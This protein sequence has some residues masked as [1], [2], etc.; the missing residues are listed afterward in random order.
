MNILD[1][2][3]RLDLESEKIEDKRRIVLFDLS[4][5]GHHPAYIQ[6]LIQYWCAQRYEGCLDIV[7]VP[8]FIQEHADVVALSHERPD[9]NFIAIT[10]KEAA[11]LWLRKS[12][13]KRTV[14][15]FQEWKLFCKYAV[16]L[17]ATHCL[18]M[19]FDTCQLP[20][21]LGLKSPCPFSG[22][23]FKPTFHYVD[24]SNHA[25]SW[26][27]SVKRR[28]ERSLLSR[29]LQHP[30]FQT[31]FCLDPFAVKYFEALQGN[32]HSVFLP[33]PVQITDDSEIQLDTLRNELNISSDKLIFLV[34]G[35]LSKRK[36]IH[37]L[38]EAVSILPPEICKKLCLLLVGETSKKEKALIESRVDALRQSR[39]VQLVSRYE[40]IPEQEVYS[41]YQLADVVLAPYQQ[42][43][44]MSGAL[45]MAA[46]A[47]KPVLSSDYGLMGKIVQHYSL[48][49]TVDSTLPVEIAK[50]LIQFFHQSPT[51]F[52][53][54]TKAK[55]FAEQNSAE[56]F[57]DTIFR[58]V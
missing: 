40:F 38:L 53:D 35:V 49:L 17:E 27:S 16:A 7:V 43:V 11:G 13:I 36:G 57:A 24:F 42:H 2:E 45:V 29:V 41:Y 22:I 23:Y 12:G 51:K 28:R 19:Y 58:Y 15:A 1:R 56:K 6:H 33:D 25:P 30:Q 50:G 14:R 55:L 18:F 20:L 34:L 4:I 47:Q 9:I 54:P 31:L 37:Q 48:G 44:G 21:A 32:T 8:K 5:Y 52:Y 26:S 39:P 10:S 3:V 46:A